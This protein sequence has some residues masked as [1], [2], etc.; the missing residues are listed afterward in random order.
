MS[1]F[2]SKF[3]RAIVSI[4][5]N[6]YFYQAMALWR[7]IQRFEPESDFVVFIVGYDEK[8]PDYQCAGFTVLDAKVLNEKEWER[9]VFQYHP[10]EASC[11]LKPQALLYLLEKYER[12]IY[13]DTDMRLFGK[14]ERG[15]KALEQR[16]LSLTPHNTTP[17]PVSGIQ[18][19][20]FIVKMSGIFNAGYVGASRG[21]ISFLKWWWQQTEYNC[22]T[23]IHMGVYLDQFYL[24]YAVTL[25]E[26]LHV[27]KDPTYNVASWNHHEREL[28]KIGSCYFVNKQP[29]TCFHFSG[30]MK[31]A[32]YSSLESRKKDLLF[33]EIFFDLFCE[34]QELLLSEKK[35]L[36]EKKYPYAHFQDGERVDKI[37]KEWLRRDIPELKNIQN[38]F[39]LTSDQ[40]ECV[41]EIMVQRPRDFRPNLDREIVLSPAIIYESIYVTTALELSA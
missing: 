7:S 9:F 17:I 14:M 38:P 12:V 41:E 13:L 20:R 23:L 39:L 22:V 35:K 32:A 11:A 34:H 26:R 4:V 2:S 37:W 3:K 16:D 21:A 27:M 29:L 19:S 24:N 25:V 8:D 18:P 1:S 31:G 10:L 15:W 40:R 5:T 36:S 28:E 6:D 33:G 30:W